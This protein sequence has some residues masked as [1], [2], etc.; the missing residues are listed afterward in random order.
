M[1]AAT[2]PVAV[3][4]TGSWLLAAVY[5]RTI[6]WLFLVAWVGIGLAATVVLGLV[7]GLAAIRESVPKGVMVAGGAAVLLGAVAYSSVTPSM[8]DRQALHD[9]GVAV[10]ATVEARWR[11]GGDGGGI[12]PGGRFWLTARAPDGTL[13]TLEAEPD[14]ERPEVG[15]PVVFTYDPRHEVRP[16][17]GPVP[18]APPWIIRTIALCLLCAGSLT[19]AAACA[20]PDSRRPEQQPQDT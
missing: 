20:L 11:D 17:L 14:E 6:E 9:R 4:V 1:I 12:A 13:W 3:V 10:T 2:V 15:R 5:R 16:E 18:G 19:A 7:L 8:T